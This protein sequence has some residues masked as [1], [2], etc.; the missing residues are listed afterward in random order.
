M[1]K[2]EQLNAD[3]QSTASVTKASEQLFE[4]AHN[5]CI[6][7]LEYLLETEGVEV[8]EQLGIMA[9][10]NESQLTTVFGE[11]FMRKLSIRRQASSLMYQASKNEQVISDQ[12]KA[13]RN[14]NSTNL[15]GHMEKPERN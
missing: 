13:A 10:A 4:V 12:L 7:E 3:L 9:T 15:V 8:L 6:A 14:E 5:D 2:V 11:Q 1:N